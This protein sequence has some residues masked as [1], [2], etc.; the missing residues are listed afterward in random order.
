MVI[1]KEE[2]DKFILAYNGDL[3]HQKIFEQFVLKYEINNKA[4]LYVLKTLINDCI[5]NIISYGE[6]LNRR[7]DKLTKLKKLELP[8]QRTPEWYELRKE[9]LTASSLAAAIGNCHFKT[10]DELIYDK[11]VETPFEPNP[12][13]EWGVK[14]EDVAIMFYEELFNVKVLDF[15]LIPHPEFTAFGASP[16][17]I[18][19]DTGNDEYLGR[20][21]E[22]KCPPKRKF[23]KTVPPAYLSQVLGQLEVCD[24]DECDFFQVKLEEYESFQEYCHDTFEID[25]VVQ[26]GRTSLNYPKSAAAT[27]KVGDK[28]SYE[29]LTLNPTNEEVKEW[30]DGHITKENFFEIKYWRIERYECTLVRRDKK[31][32]IDTIDKIL[33]FYNDL[34]HYKN[35][36]EE[37]GQLK[38][39]IDETKKRKKKIEVVPLDKFQLIS[40]DEDN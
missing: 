29:F 37:L 26:K 28:L 24:L 8:E 3:N 33:K 23:T 36:S 14:Y 40:D 10:R 6:V 4:E 38:K 7:R 31:W 16:D 34:N 30:V 12:I 17:G 5:E 13:T 18:C 19:E 20:M 2:I 15:G 21:V 9:I 32:W 35:D 27:Y 22:I 39:R 11:I 1:M 25:G